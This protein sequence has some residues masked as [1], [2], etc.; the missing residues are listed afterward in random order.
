MIVEVL[1]HLLGIVLLL[2]M[3]SSLSIVAVYL[4]CNTIIIV[5]N[6]IV[7]VKKWRKR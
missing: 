7:V 4:T 3:I 6:T 2:F 1:G 5:H